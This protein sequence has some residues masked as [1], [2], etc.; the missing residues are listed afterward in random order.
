LAGL[1]A[2]SGSHRAAPP[3]KPAAPREALPPG[4]IVRLGSLRFWHHAEIVAIAFSPDGTLLASGGGKGILR[5]WDPVTG[6][7]ASWLPP[8]GDLHSISALA[9]A[10]DGRTL[11]AGGGAGLFLWDMHTR[12]PLHHFGLPGGADFVA[13]SP[14]GR[15]LASG[16]SG[17]SAVYLWEVATGKELRRFVGGEDDVLT[18][19][20]A[21]DGKLL[22][23][24]GGHGRIHLWD[25]ATGKERLRLTDERL[26]WVASVAF[27]PDGTV[28]AAGG[29]DEAVLLWDVATGKALPSLRGHE[30][31]V[32]AVAFSP[33][34]RYL[35]SASRDRTVRL[36]DR[37]TGKE[38]TCLRGHADRVRAVVFHPDGR[39]VASVA[40]GREQTIRIWQ[41]AT[42][43]PAHHFTGHRTAVVAAAVSPD[44]RTL[45]SGS[46]D[47]SVCLW[48][49]DT[50]QVRHTLTGHKGAVRTLAFSHDGK[51]LASGSADRSVRLWQAAT[52]KE[53][54]AF[55]LTGAA[56]TGLEFAAT[57]RSLLAA[58]DN[59]MEW[60][61]ASG[62]EVQFANADN[63]LAFS[64]RGEVLTR[65]EGTA[66]PTAA[67][68]SRREGDR[69]FLH[70]ASGK[71]LAEF[72]TESK[73]LATPGDTQVPH[74]VLATAFAADGRRLAAIC[75]G[76]VYLW[77]V[78]TTKE[79]ARFTIPTGTYQALALSADS[80]YLAVAYPDQ[81]VGLWE[82]ATGKELRQFQGHDD[83]VT[84]LVFT[85]D[86]T[87]LVSASSDTTLFVWDIT[88]RRHG[89]ILLPV[90]LIEADL[91]ALWADLLGD[92]ARRADD[93]VWK[94]VAGRR[95]AVPFLGK[96][97]HPVPKVDGAQIARLI[98][99]LD[100]KRFPVRERAGTEL[101][102]LG[103]RA[104]FALRQTLEKR[105]TLE[106]RRRIE[107]LL[108]RL[109]KPR[110]SRAEVRV[111]RAQAVL[112]YAESTEAQAVLQALAQGEPGARLTAEAQAALDR[113]E[114]RRPAGH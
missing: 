11:V 77:D 96:R 31:S 42:G 28:L 109:P 88:G 41:V 62:K 82:A 65:K 1:L 57:D 7:Q 80:R 84:A 91:D 19:A 83:A 90:I 73:V 58:N 12:K 48:R 52:G 99:D 17:K 93:A 94:L 36:W 23:T 10:P 72:R 46:E 40:E 22:A 4:A 74:G 47:G 86:G 3:A 81:R 98:A 102:Q 55:V 114:K 87:A 8:Q 32:T 13:F 45:A 66:T 5:L 15:T 89:G 60:D 95:Q 16:G 106:V 26:E 25:P 105:P 104:E 113:S 9:F 103:E 112:E 14:D 53:I 38:N 35:A 97:L 51:I 18:A 2:A 34:G 27:S 67:Q 68:G 71:D 100:D 85:P 79:L 63:F 108:A 56:V 50:G 76:E 69:L 33:D 111:L 37:A 43:K 30:N 107:H 24:A 70:S 110:L 64:P 61:A 44:G 21:P 39:T 29:A 101:Q 6:Q 78:A 92:D 54:R 49:R 59:L 75:P 20:F